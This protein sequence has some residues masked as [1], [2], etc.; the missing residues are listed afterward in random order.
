MKRPE[1]E[2]EAK[3]AGTTAQGPEQLTWK[4]SS[5]IWT[6]LAHT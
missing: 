1:G 5:E 6:K 2:R 4:T 3:W